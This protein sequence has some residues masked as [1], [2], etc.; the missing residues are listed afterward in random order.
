MFINM[1]VH[2]KITYITLKINQA[3]NNPM[4]IAR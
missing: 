2:K 1:N 3:L 4:R